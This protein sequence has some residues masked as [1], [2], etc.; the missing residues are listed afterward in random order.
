MAQ[1]ATRYGLD[2]PGI[3][4]RWGRDFPH[5]SSPALSFPAVKR[6]GRGVDHPPPSGAEVKGRVELYI[7]WPSGSP[8]PVLGWTLPCTFIFTF[9]LISQRKV[10]LLLQSSTG[11]SMFPATGQPFWQNKLRRNVFD[12]SGCDFPRFSS[13]LGKISRHNWK[14]QKLI[15][16]KWSEVS[17]DEVLGDKSAMYIR[18]TLHSGYLII[19]WL[20]KLGIYCTVFVLTCTVIVSACFIMCGCVYVWVL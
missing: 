5:P 2:G 6:P 13:F 18:V 10:S 7:Y 3:E 8:W 9:T 15:E 14:T 20:F 12:Y 17:Y 19:L 1:S 11:R 4:S 16:V